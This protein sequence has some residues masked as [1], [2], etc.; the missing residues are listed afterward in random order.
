MIIDKERLIKEII[1]KIKKEMDTAVVA[2]SGGADST[3][4]TIL[5]TKALGPEN[6]YSLHM[7][8]GDRDRKKFNANSELIADRLKINSYT[9]PINEISDSIRE[10]S[11]SFILPMNKVNQG[12]CRSR[13]RMTLL[14]S[15]SHELGLIGK[16]VRVVG[17]GNLSEDYIGY[18][19]KG[20]DAL[21]DIFPIG[22]LFKSEV[23]ELLDYF[24]SEGVI[25]DEMVD[26]VPSAGLWDDQSDEDEL[27]YTYNEMELAIRKNL[28]EDVIVKEDV[29]EFVKHR[30]VSHKHKHEAP[31]VIFLRNKGIL[32]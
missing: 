7:P 14:Y 25:L 29:L 28:G 2:M 6:V 31:K 15:V 5:L 10:A 4:V 20:G 30:H 17:T 27:G 8:Y 12:N 24:V 19:T 9:M 11:S 1:T 26:R 18:D 13:A 23:Y 21:A 16:K 22:E 3:L 32:K